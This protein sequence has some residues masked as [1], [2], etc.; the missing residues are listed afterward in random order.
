MPQKPKWPSLQEQLAAVKPSGGSALEKLIQNNQDFSLLDPQEA[1]DS[2]DLP[3]WLRVYWRK[4]HP[5]LTHPKI[6]PGAAYPDVLHTIHARML[7]N[8]DLPGIEIR[9]EKK[10]GK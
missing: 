5:E 4:A 7:A 8:H 3:L 2:Y 9:S 1:Q 10:G 6:N